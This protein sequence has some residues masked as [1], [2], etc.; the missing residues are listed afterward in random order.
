MFSKIANQNKKDASIMLQNQQLSLSLKQKPIIEIKLNP[1]PIANRIAS[2]NQLNNELMLQ[3]S[4]IGQQASMHFRNVVKPMTFTQEEILHEFQKEEGFDYTDPT[5]GKTIKIRNN[6]INPPPKLDDTPVDVVPNFTDKFITYEDLMTENDEYNKR[7]SLLAITLEKLNERLTFNIY[8]TKRLNDAIDICTDLILEFSLKKEKSKIEKIVRDLKTD[9]D[10]TKLNIEKLKLEHKK[11]LEDVDEHNAR[12]TLK[13]QMN[14]EA[15]NEYKN[16]LN[17]LNSD[18]FQMQQLPSETEQQYL[19][20]IQQNALVDIPEHQLEDATRRIQKTFREKMKE[21]INSP[22]KID[23]VCNTID[24][25]GDVDNKTKLL[26]IWTYVKNKFEGIY[27]KDNKAVTPQEIVELFEIILTQ[28]LEEV[29]SGIKA[30]THSGNAGYISLVADTTEN[31]LVLTNN[32]TT[33]DLFLKSV[34]LSGNHQK[35]DSQTNKLTFLYS[36][37]GTKNSFKQYFDT[38]KNFHVPPTRKGGNNKV[39]QSGDEIEN[40][41]GITRT[42]INAIFNIRGET[43][44]DS[45]IA[46]EMYKI[47]KIEPLQIPDTSSQ[48]PYKVKKA[49]VNQHIEYGYGIKSEN[50][51]KF[52]EFGSL[53]VQMKKLYYQ[54]ILS[55]KDRNMKSINGL[56]NWKSSEKF[57][58]IILNMLE[59]IHPTQEEISR[60]SSPE[61]QYYDRMIHLG[62]LHKQIPHTHEKTIMELKKRLKLLE[63]EIEIGNNSPQIKQEIKKILIHLHQLNVITKKQIDEHLKQF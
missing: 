30:T 8:E 15:I 46:K 25:L 27:G 63:A 6:V 36:F 4:R 2:K 28:G 29:V 59:G 24:P 26:K 16:E 20:R 12:M 60:L 61:R 18:R 53:L 56:P 10:K 35:P 48:V 41:T 42:D 62:K 34:F 50:I 9:I 45:T 37:D 54:H 55:V 22:V 44:N 57:A 1:S 52:V 43:I 49:D 31:V 21:L 47:F 14:R 38:G 58:S 39:N 11:N 7:L 23:Q 33:K 17:A 13:Q 40:K 19:D 5:T 3:N 32:K 51:P